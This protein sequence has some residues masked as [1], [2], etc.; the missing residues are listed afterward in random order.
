MSID[1]TISDLKAP[2]C[3]TNSPVPG[4]ARAFRGKGKTSVSH[5]RDCQPPADTARLGGT[6]GRRRQMTKENYFKKVRA[7]LR[8]R[9]VSLDLNMAETLR[10]CRLQTSGFSPVSTAKVIIANRAE[11]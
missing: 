2:L 10:V 5:T 11:G 1:G 6:Q 4:A 8:Q 3:H 9:D 7:A